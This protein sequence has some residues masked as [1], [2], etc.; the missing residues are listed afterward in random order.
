MNCY[1]CGEEITYKNSSLEHII[2]NAIGGKL[3][4]KDLICIKCNSKFGQL[5]DIEL[6][7]QMNVYANMLNISRDR[8]KPPNLEAKTEEGESSYRIAPGGK[9][10]LVK[11]Y[12]IKRKNNEYNY[13]VPPNRL[14]DFKKELISK[15]GKEGKK[16]IITKE[17]RKV[18]KLDKQLILELPYYGKIFLTAINKIAIN[19]YIYKQ[20]DSF[21][22]QTLIEKLKKNE[23]IFENVVL[24]SLRSE[25]EIK[26]KELTAI[27]H[28]II[29][30]RSKEEKKIYMYIEFFSSESFLIL[31]SDEYEG[32]NYMT[33]YSYD[34]ISRDEK[35]N[36]INNENFK[37]I[38]K[39]WVIQKDLDIKK[40][41]LN[42]VISFILSKQ[43]K[44]NF[45]EEFFNKYSE[46]CQN[47][48]SQ[49]IKEFSHIF[50]EEIVKK[51]Y[52]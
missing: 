30:K 25:N 27:Y 35:W 24:Y 50:A 49:N 13:E 41:K 32:E 44:D 10:L 45:M 52:P 21:H 34:V 5:L 3:K 29:L 38:K 8:G 16:I 12:I 11:P 43:K 22:I 36:T 46:I 7:K 40:A 14:K 18:E 48:T 42:K 31:L 4:S 26:E 19:F 23:Y 37:Y 28:K 17:K 51:F 15:F 39:D 6:A 9:P 1:L 20:K 2:P 47:I 33:S